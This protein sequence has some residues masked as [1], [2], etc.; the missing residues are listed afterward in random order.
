MKKIFYIAF[1]AA[2]L[3]AVSCAKN[4]ELN[5]DPTES[6]QELTLKFTLGDMPT[7]AEGDEATI[8]EVDSENNENRVIRIDYFIFPL[9][10]DGKVADDTEYVFDGAIEE[11]RTAGHELDLSYEEVIAPHKLAQI[12]PNGAKKAMVFAV[13]NYLS[14]DGI[15]VKTWRDI[16]NLEVDDTFTCDAGEGYGRRWPHPM[17]TNNPELY[18]VM[19]AEQV[20]ELK[21]TGSYAIEAEIPLRRLASKVTVE[22]DFTDATYTD[23]KGVTWIPET[24]VNPKPEK[25]EARVYLSNAFCNATLGG[26]LSR[27]LV[28]DGKKTGETMYVP[29]DDR[30]IFEYA[31]DYL[32]NAKVD[33]LNYYYTYPY[34]KAVDT[35]GDNQPYLKLV[36]P[37]YGY[38]NGVFYK[39]KEVYYKII[40]PSENITESN[41]IYQYVVDVKIIGSET[42]VEV[43]GEEYKV[44]EWLTSDGVESSVATGRFISLDIPKDTYDMYT[45]LAEILFVSSGDVTPIV[46]EI[47]QWNYSG[48]T[49]TKDYFMQ[50]NAVP[51]SATQGN[52]SLLGKKGLTTSDVEGWVTIPAGTSE[53]RISHQL[54]NDMNVTPK[55]KFDAAPYVYKVRLHLDAAGSDTSFD[56][57]IT[58]TQ[59]PAMYII[60]ETNSDYNTTGEHY[61]YVYIHGQQ[62]TNIREWYRVTGLSGLN[63]NPNMFI[64]TSTVLT[65]PDM[66]LGDPRKKTIQNSYPANGNNTWSAQAPYMYSS[67]TQRRLSYY[68]PTDDSD[69]AKN[70]VSPK[71]RIAS[72][73]G[74]TG[75]VSRQEA[76]QR[77]ASYQ[78]D[79]YPAGRWRVPTTA[80]VKYVV[81]LST[82]GFMDILFG[83]PATSN[84][85]TPYW[86]STGYVTVNNY[87]KTVNDYDGDNDEDTW[88]RCVYDD[89]YWSDKAS[90]KTAF[91]W[92]DK[93]R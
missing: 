31:Y 37:W 38:K 21:T 69:V 35:N 4:A 16:H 82:N 46:E 30:D 74:K 84:E 39:K 87:T 80:E 9:G 2:A 53:L 47:Y 23:D 24:L 89:W 62:A 52:P 34:P 19:T 91:I 58:I 67:E 81:N 3:A 73:Y 63:S 42:E 15:T 85:T 51:T 7:R 25:E 45:S 64:I 26:P 65:D 32:H 56:R 61:G 12:F 83:N 29:R 70:M 71:F 28:P 41:K 55:S 78:E 72:S 68:Y 14:K 54:C 90:D 88:V 59:Y 20:V 60:A 76:F 18:F 13:A 79:G 27:T 50:N 33:S 93:Q 75:A 49:P 36:L 40:L 57:T 10:E 17:Q 43:T 8:Q 92:G 48:T 22:L 1:A 5:S 77:C 6:A 66:V 11:D 86:T 44:K